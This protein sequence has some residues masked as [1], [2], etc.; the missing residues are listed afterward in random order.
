MPAATSREGA[1][2]PSL[3][4][5]LEQIREAATL[6]N[7]CYRDAG[8]GLMFWEEA[9]VPAELLETKTRLESQREPFTSEALRHLILH[10]RVDV[11]DRVS[12]AG[13][14]VYGYF[15]SLEEAVNA[16]WERL[17]LDGSPP[18][19]RLQ[20]RLDAAIDCQLDEENLHE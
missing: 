20:Q 9:R 12:K 4:Q 13:L 2:A 17:D 11:N 19:S 7:I 15:P 8:V 1:S 5:K 14:V 10:N 3:L 16:E 6:H 18:R